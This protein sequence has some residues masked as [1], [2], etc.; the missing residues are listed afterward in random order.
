MQAK[1]I[2]AGER[3]VVIEQNMPGILTRIN[4]AK[5]NVDPSRA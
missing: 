4:P 1:I 3:L 2:I 5:I